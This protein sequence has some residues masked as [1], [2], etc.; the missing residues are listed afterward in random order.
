VPLFPTAHLRPKTT[1]RSPAPPRQMARTCRKEKQSARTVRPKTLSAKSNKK[2]RSENREDFSRKR[3]VY[4]FRGDS[5]LRNDDG[6]PEKQ[7]AMFVSR[8]RAIEGKTS[9]DGME[10]FFAQVVTV[11]AVC[12]LVACSPTSSI[13]ALLHLQ[14]AAVNSRLRPP[15][16]WPP[17]CF[18]PPLR[19]SLQLRVPPLH[20]TSRRRR[21]VS[22][23]PAAYA[24]GAAARVSFSGYPVP[25]T[26]LTPQ[27]RAPL[28]PPLCFPFPPQPTRLPLPPLVVHAPGTP[29][30]VRPTSP[31]PP[32]P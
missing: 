30:P 20:N 15:Y 2:R 13:P 9:P 18:T 27:V 6:R 1:P 31:P 10:G 17:S 26:L 23:P 24:S 11:S 12:A 19:S 16:P 22:L 4:A 5:A 28:P 3:K 29:P 32:S 21:C 14:P 7:R 8:P 25:D